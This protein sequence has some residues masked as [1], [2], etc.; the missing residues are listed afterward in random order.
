MMI[1]SRYLS[2]VNDFL[3]I[4]FLNLS[5]ML[6]KSIQIIFSLFVFEFQMIMITSFI[7]SSF[8]SSKN[9]AFFSISLIIRMTFVNF[10]L[11]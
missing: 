11:I 4:D 7:K 5:L 9:H 6:L 1:F 10:Y 2:L 3:I 8:I